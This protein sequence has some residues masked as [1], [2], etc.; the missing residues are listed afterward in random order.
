MNDATRHP[1]TAQSGPTTPISSDPMELFSLYITDE[2]V[3]YIVRY[4]NMYAEQTMTNEEFSKWTPISSKE[5][6]A[7]IGFNILMGLAK[8]PS[9]NDYWNK[10]PVFHY[11]PIASRITRDRFRDIRRYL[12]FV[13]NKTLP[14]PRSP[15][16]DR[17]AKI[18][19]VLN[20]VTQKCRTVYLPK[21]DVSVDEAMIKFQGRSSLK[22]YLP[23]KPVKRGIKVWVLANTNGY[24]WNMQVHNKYLTQISVTTCD[25]FTLEERQMQRKA[26]GQG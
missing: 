20:F 24:F 12:H 16:S 6:R 21:R 25:R 26:L 9:I 8:L 5:L 19:P 10:S 23:M 7:Y 13:D 22:Q 15:G 11:S 17:L 3:E 1:F 2:L 4:S 14:P 18:R